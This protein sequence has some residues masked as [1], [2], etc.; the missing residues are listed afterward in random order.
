[1]NRNKNETN[2]KSST[3]YKFS[4]FMISSL[5]NLQI[6][7]IIKLVRDGHVFIE[8]QGHISEKVFLPS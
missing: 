2:L 1:M 3:F 5:M 8:A 4:D 7:R 6:L